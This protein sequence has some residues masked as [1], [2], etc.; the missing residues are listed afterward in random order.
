MGLSVVSSSEEAGVGLE[1][2]T[3]PP[4]ESPVELDVGASVAL[5][6]PASDVDPD[7]GSDVG[8]PEVAPAVGLLVS[9]ATEA[10][11]SSAGGIRTASI[12]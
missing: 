4:A 2:V 8:E 11:S 5:M 9:T 10:S 1:V 6:P 7:V 12:T 3:L